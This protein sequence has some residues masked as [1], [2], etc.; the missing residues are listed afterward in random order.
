M[1]LK[2][3][4]AIVGGWLGDAGCKLLIGAFGRSYLESLPLLK[5]KFRTGKFTIEQRAR[6]IFGTGSVLNCYGAVIGYC[7]L[8]TFI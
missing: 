1:G 6:A 4:V 3:E 8:P 7:F 2:E 5:Q